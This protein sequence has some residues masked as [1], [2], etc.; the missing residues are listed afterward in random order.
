M[1]LQGI[2]YMEEEG[3]AGDRQ[4]RFGRLIRKAPQASAAPSDKDD[5]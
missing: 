2:E 5:G 1:G 4:K 3:P